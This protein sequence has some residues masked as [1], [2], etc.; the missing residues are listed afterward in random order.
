VDGIA[1]EIFSIQK[2][3]C[4]KQLQEEITSG[5]DKELGIIRSNFVH[6]VEDLS[7]KRSRLYVH[8]SLGQWHII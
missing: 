3:E 7:R 2:E 4:D 8:H 5:E 6:Q 1:Q